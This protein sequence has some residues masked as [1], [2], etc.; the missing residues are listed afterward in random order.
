MRRSRVGRPA[1]QFLILFAST[2]LAQTP[3][4]PDTP[5]LAAGEIRNSV[6]GAPIERAHIVLQKFANGG[7]D[8]YGAF[9]NAE[10]KFT[11]PNLPPGE[12]SI[13]LDKTGFVDTN[14][15][16]GKSLTLHSGDK[17]DALQWKLTPTGSITGQVLDADGRP[18]ESILV[19]TDTGD[20]RGAVTDDR[21]FYR[22][23]GLRPGKYRVKATPEEIPIPPEIRT[24]TTVE[25]HY[26]ATYHPNALD[27]QSAARVLVGPATEVTGIDIHLVRTPILHIGGRVSGMPEGSRNASVSLRSAGGN[28]NGAQVRQD[29]TFEIWRPSPGKYTIQ[30]NWYN[31]ASPLSSAPVEIEIGDSDVENLDL[32]LRPAEDLQGRVDFLDEEARNLP[33]PPQRRSPTGLPPVPAQRQPRRIGLRYADGSQLGGAAAVGDDGSFTLSKVPPGKYRVYI[34]APR[35]YVQSVQ[36]GQTAMEGATLDIRNGSAGAPLTVRVASATGAVQG[37]VTGEKGPVSGARVLLGEAIGNRI[38]PSFTTTK[39]DGSY[40]FTAVAPGKY[41][42]MVIDDADAATINQSAPEDYEDIAEH[43][44]ISDHQTV[45][46]DLKKPKP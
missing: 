11:I 31:G 43:I 38:T 24:D 17:K 44:E 35:V 18:V 42:I 1:C 45:N 41:M 27:A 7:T 33:P 28:S 29:G 30:A 5:A 22:I 4:P 6:D 34:A 26:S 3:P 21:G 9:T 13:M 10:G 46:K 14:G 25:V 15:P 40:S 36:L 8:R 16:S 23:G 37:I 32:Q 20:R 39:E 12:Y 19:M 2:L